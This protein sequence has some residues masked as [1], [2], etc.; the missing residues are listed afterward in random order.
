MADTDPFAAALS[1]STKDP[2]AKAMEGAKTD[3]FA[4]ALGKPPGNPVEGFVK[5]AHQHPFEAFTNAISA[6]DRALQA[7]ETGKNPASAFMDPNQGPA[8][9]KAVKDKI[10]LSALEAGPLAGSDLPHKVMRGTADFTLDAVNS[11]WNLVP[12]GKI[13]EGIGKGVKAIPGAVKAGEKLA[14]S[15]LGETVSN[16]FNPDHYIRG[17]NDE[18]KARYEM[19]TN[20]AMQSVR[21]RRAAEDA[22][23]AK[24]ADSIRAGQMPSDVARLFQ[25]DP[26]GS[27]AYSGP[28]DAW[29]EAFIDKKTGK[30][31]FGPGTKPQDVTAALFRHRA[32]QFQNQAKA[33]LGHLFRNPADY[34]SP[35]IP[36]NVPAGITMNEK[37]HRIAAIQAELL[38]NLERK[39]E[40]DPSVVQGLMHK[41]VHR[42][43]QAFLSNVVPHPLN[44]TSLAYNRY[45]PVTAAKG[46]VNAA[47][48]AA[49]KTGGKLGQNIGE[50]SRTGSHFQYA[51]LY[52][53][54][55][56]TRV[57]GIPGT[58]GAAKAI[59]KVT[60]PMERAQNYLQEKGLNS[61]ETGLRSAALDT[62]RKKGITGAQAARDLNAGFG[63]N[64][65]TGFTRGLQKLP[66]PFAQFHAQTAP[67]SGLRA[68]AKSPNRIRV[69]DVAQRDENQQVNPGGPEYRSTT[70][71]FSV[72]RAVVDP[73]D[74]F[75]DFG[76]LG[77]IK[78]AISEAVRKKDVG[79]TLTRGTLN[80]VP[81]SQ[82][83]ATAAQLAQH[84]KGPKGEDPLGDLISAIVGGYYV[85]K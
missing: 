21:A 50:L 58:E 71:T 8:L 30:S 26:K 67:G 75:T 23:V 74:Y 29:K 11:P 84:K 66:V 70:P 33:Q 15:K 9:E 43:N 53:E 45:G 48:V 60:I 20:R 7:V 31:T 65:P 62:L 54:M 22:I 12:V 51:P 80:Y 42:G 1:Q 61:V 28:V 10:G 6:P 83:A 46:L 4:S 49:G 82:Q 52:D 34:N 44:L 3:P 72:A 38:R 40:V 76:P 69:A 41:I 59:N 14:D 79:G 64:A 55:G 81:G 77:T 17:L 68:L 16:W 25:L 19:A 63:S 56:I 13:A 2:F 27:G 35:K 24:H 39:P 18:E 37:Q 5:Y 85:K 73:E 57:A 36:F 78:S 32:P 47:R